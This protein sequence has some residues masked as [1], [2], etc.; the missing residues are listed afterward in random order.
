MEIAVSHAQGRVPVTVFRIKGEIDVNSYEQLQ[1][2][3]QAAVEAGD[4]PP[5]AL[6]RGSGAADQSI[7]SLTGQITSLPNSPSQAEIQSFASQTD[8]FLATGRVL[9]PRYYSRDKGLFSSNPWPAYERRDFPRLGFLLINQS[10]AQAIFPSR[11]IPEPFP[12]AGDAIILGCQREDYLEVRLIAFPEQDA[13][14]M[15]A[16]LSEPCSP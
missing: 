6:K 16:P 10:V 2:Q 13:V 3:A 7:A 11:E 9:Y 15:S 1:A 12:H 4:H 5:R 8:A 14:L